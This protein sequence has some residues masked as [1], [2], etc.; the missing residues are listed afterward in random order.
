MFISLTGPDWLSQ[1]TT[2][3]GEVLQFDPSLLEEDA[4][5]ERR[6]EQKL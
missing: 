5:P 1:L 2:A 6:L 3:D 4:K